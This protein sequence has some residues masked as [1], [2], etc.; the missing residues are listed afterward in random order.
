MKKLFLIVLGC[1]LALLIGYAGYLSYSKAKE[2]RS[3]SLA[4]Q[5]IAKSDIRNAVL[6]LSK[7]LHANPRNVDAARL[8]GDMAEANQPEALLWRKR[9]VQL[10]PHSQTDIIALASAA[11]SA[12]DLPLAT[13]SLA[14][15]TKAY[16]NTVAY[17]NVAGAVAIAERNPVLAESYFKQASGLD[18][19]NLVPQM[20]YAILRL[21]S[22]NQQAVA[23]AKVALIRIADGT[24]QLFR[25]QA[26][27]ELTGD[28]Y[29]HGQ[30][31]TARHLS[32]RLLA[33]TNSMFNDRV[34]QLEILQ[35]IGD[36]SFATAL[37]SAQAAAANDPA[38]TFTLAHWELKTYH[39]PRR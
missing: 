26:L 19:D 2:I 37:A 35:R 12:H 20:N 36:G 10:A 16:Q 24:N 6:S 8:M 29:V 15:V 28:A 14:Q 3:M 4:R 13:N 25:T 11:L 18:P 38:R 17:Q 27:R 7:V 22:T 21:H 34:M 39:P 33:E 32:E 23:E 1:T 5:F 30:L 9:V 31:N